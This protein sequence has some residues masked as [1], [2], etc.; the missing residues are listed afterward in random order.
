MSDSRSLISVLTSL[1]LVLAF[2][3]VLLGAYTRL[4]NAG[5][6]CPDWPGCY[7]HLLP[8]AESAASFEPQKAWTEMLHRYAAGTLGLLIFCIGLIAVQKRATNPAFPWRLPLALCGLVIFQALL[9]KWTVTMKLFPVVVMAHLLGGILIFASLCRL[10]L[11]LCHYQQTALLVWQPW[12]RL[13]LVIVFLQIAL[14]GWVSSNYAGLACIG[15]PQCN[16]LWLPTFDFAHSLHLFSSPTINYQGGIF[17]SP[18]RISIQWVHRLGAIVTLSYLLILAILIQWKS[19]TNWLKYCAQ[20]IALLVLIQFTLGILNVLYLLPLE[21]AIAHNGVAALLF[22][23]LFSLLYAIQ[24]K[25]HA[26]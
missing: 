24:G 14:G 6:G 17:D 18:V 19:K 15:F 22:A 12:L 9:G 5:L 16:G 13:A 26:R 10:R 7:G 21:I 2:F 3:V 4:S 25:V 23:S 11:Q 8:K 20:G 1:A